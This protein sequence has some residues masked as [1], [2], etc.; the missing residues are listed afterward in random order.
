[1][2]ELLPSID[3]FSDEKW[4]LGP[5]RDLKWGRLESPEL[6]SYHSFNF[7]IFHLNFHLPWLAICVNEVRTIQPLADLPSPLPVL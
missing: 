4:K 3:Q 5:A 6:Y 7:T 1:M 2:V